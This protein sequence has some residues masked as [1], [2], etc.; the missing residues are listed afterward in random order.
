MGEKGVG[1]WIKFFETVAYIHLQRQ[2]SLYLK[3]V[4]MGAGWAPSKN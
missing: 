2:T 4:Q 1:T 3:S